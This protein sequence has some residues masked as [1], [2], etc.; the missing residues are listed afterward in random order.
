MQTRAILHTYINTFNLYY[1]NLYVLQK[2]L[3]I[4]MLDSQLLKFIL[5]MQIYSRS[6][7]FNVTA[8]LQIDPQKY[9]PQR[10]HLCD[11]ILTSECPQ[12]MQ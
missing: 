4:K 1:F 7:V 10:I 5:Y 2:W 11:A 12:M 3:H 8:L 6:A 9:I